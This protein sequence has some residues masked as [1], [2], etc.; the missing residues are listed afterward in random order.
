MSIDKYISF[1][2]SQPYEMTEVL[3]RRVTGFFIFLSVQSQVLIL[4][5][6]DYRVFR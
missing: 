6:D 4:L 3:F 5:L 2:E 1:S